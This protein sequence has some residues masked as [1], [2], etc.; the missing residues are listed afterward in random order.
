MEK[1]NLNDL[2]IE[3]AGWGC[4]KYGP[5]DMLWDSDFTAFISTFSRSYDFF[6]M[7]GKKVSVDIF[8]S[9]LVKKQKG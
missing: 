7:D 6:V 9:G 2:E 3:R 8:I 5:V 4:G 1:E